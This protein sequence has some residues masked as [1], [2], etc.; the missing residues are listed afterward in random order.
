MTHEDHQKDCIKKA[1]KNY[2]KFLQTL[3]DTKGS[4]IDVAKTTGIIFG[5]K[6]AYELRNEAKIQAFIDIGKDV[7][8]KQ[9]DDFRCGEIEGYATVLRVM[10]ND[11]VCRENLQVLNA[12]C[13][14]KS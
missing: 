3:K 2:E 12:Y 6:D 14:F 1:I 13:N 11:K 8:I 9:L 7:Y 10:N 5:L 4:V